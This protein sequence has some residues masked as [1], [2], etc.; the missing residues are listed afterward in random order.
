MAAVLASILEGVG[1]V[2]DLR[3]LG[4]ST[5]KQAQKQREAVVRLLRDIYFTPRGSRQV[6]EV[7]ARG[8]APSP[9]D[10][11]IVLPDFNDREWMVLRH[12]DRTLFE[13]EDFV[14]IGLRNRRVLEMIGYGKKNLRRDIQ[15]LLNETLT[16]RR[17]VPAEEAQNILERVNELNRS[18]EDLEREFL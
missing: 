18:I 5:Q 12:I 10:I 1:L 17:P 13:S 15:S 16:K 8:E 9:E 6:V 3:Q 11:E 14:H 4:P 7:L 2:N